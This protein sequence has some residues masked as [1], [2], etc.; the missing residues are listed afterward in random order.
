M[1]LWEIESFN[2][3]VIREISQVFLPPFECLKIKSLEHRNYAHFHPKLVLGIHH[4]SSNLLE[5]HQIVSPG[6]G[7]ES[8][9]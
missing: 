8:L 2:N 6:F 4:I 1:E 9:S 3:A 7:L 5:I